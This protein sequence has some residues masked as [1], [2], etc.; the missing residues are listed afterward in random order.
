MFIRD[1][2]RL[3]V[4]AVTNSIETARKVQILSGIDSIVVKEYERGSKTM[5]EA[6]K[7]QVDEG[8]VSPGQKIVA[9]SGSPKAI[10]GVTSTARLYKVSETGEIIGTE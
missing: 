8:V 6:L 2:P 4:T 10:S 7:A 9:I 3:P 1:R 5:Q